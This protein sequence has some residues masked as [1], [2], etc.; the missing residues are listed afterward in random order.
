MVPTP[1]IFAVHSH[2]SLNVVLKKNRIFVGTLIYPY[3]MDIKIS[4]RYSQ[5][6]I[7]LFNNTL[8]NHMSGN[9]LHRYFKGQVPISDKILIIMHQ[10]LWNLI[11]KTSKNNS[12]NRKFS[13]KNWDAFRQIHVSI[14]ESISSS[15][16]FLFSVESISEDVCVQFSVFLQ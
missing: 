16:L 9:S 12:G 7:F 13:T 4:E 1:E 14:P 6:K 11:A 2:I 10:S 15:Q 5:R 8:E 3:F